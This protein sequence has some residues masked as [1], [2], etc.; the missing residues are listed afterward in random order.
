MPRTCT[1][2]IHD[3]RPAIDQALISGEPFR[4]IATRT[5][6]STGALQRHKSEHLPL[7]LRKAHDAEEIAHADTLLDQIR[8]LQSRA[9]SILAKAEKAGDLRTALAA[10]GQARGV[11]ELQAKVTGET[12]KSEAQPSAVSLRVLIQN[13]IALPKVGAGVPKSLPPSFPG[14]RT[15][16]VEPAK[17]S[18][19]D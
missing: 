3:D 17:G 7:S 4:H 10:I 2:C 12:D 5:G 11:M 9:M 18:S 6:T 13:T 1:I 16:T 19:E 8:E 15:F 14:G